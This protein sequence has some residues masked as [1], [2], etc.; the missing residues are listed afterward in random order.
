MLISNVET[1]VGYLFDIEKPWSAVPWF[2][3]QYERSHCPGDAHH[4][5]QRRYQLCEESN[6]V[7]GQGAWA[8]Q[9]FF[10]RG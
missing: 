3:A 7:T 2:L 4:G 5:G 1:Y 6:R 9:C 8:A 10:R